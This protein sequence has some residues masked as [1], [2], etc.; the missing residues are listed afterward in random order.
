M[1]KTIYNILIKDFFKRINMIN[2]YK[3]QILNY[4]IEKFSLIVKNDINTFFS[5]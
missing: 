5:S 1:E 2:G 4:N 3:K